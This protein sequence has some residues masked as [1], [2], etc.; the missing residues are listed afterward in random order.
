MTFK[1]RLYWKVSHILIKKKE[2]KKKSLT[3]QTVHVQ[4]CTIFNLLNYIY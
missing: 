2:S 1:R 4:F 3:Y